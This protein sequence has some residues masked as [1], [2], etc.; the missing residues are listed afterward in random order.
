[1]GKSSASAHLSVDPDRFHDLF[2]RR[3]F[4]PSNPGVT[5]N[6]VWALGDVSDGDG[7]QLLRHFGQRSATEDRSTECFKRIIDFRCEFVAARSH[8]RIGDRINR[9][10]QVFS[11][12][13]SLCTSFILDVP[14]SYRHRR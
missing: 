8:L 5:V 1:V 4:V 11:F 13:S 12:F 7:D 3:A 10:S 9:F 2:V 14:I 6:A